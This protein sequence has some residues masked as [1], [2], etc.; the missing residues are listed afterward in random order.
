MKQQYHH[1]ESKKRKMNPNHQMTKSQMIIV[2]CK[3]RR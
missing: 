1:L 2:F 3:L